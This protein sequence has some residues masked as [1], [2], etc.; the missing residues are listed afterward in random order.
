[1]DKRD[2][3]V[4][5]YRGW[6]AKDAS[7]HVGPGPSGFDS[8]FALGDARGGDNVMGGA[9]SRSMMDSYMSQRGAVNGALNGWGGGDPTGSLNLDVNV[10]GPRGTNVDASVTEGD[11]IPADRGINVNREMTEE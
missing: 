5:D 4:G 11:F 10:K 8:A 3:A 2:I 1:M 9:L 6:S 7:Q